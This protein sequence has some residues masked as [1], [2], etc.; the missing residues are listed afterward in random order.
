MW[1]LREF[2]M[3][4][5]LH[6]VIMLHRGIDLR[7]KALL[8]VFLRSNILHRIKKKVNTFH[9]EKFIFFCYLSVVIP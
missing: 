9:Y 4:A 6:L 2:N 3:I 8:V 7:G 5:I 1:F